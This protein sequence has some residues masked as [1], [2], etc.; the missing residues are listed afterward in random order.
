MAETEATSGK[1][2]EAEMAILRAENDHLKQSNKKL[3]KKL[4]EAQVVEDVDDE[5]EEPLY[6][7]SAV[8]AKVQS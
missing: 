5:S 8:K 4:D 3:Q 7:T 1:Q 6:V 2:R